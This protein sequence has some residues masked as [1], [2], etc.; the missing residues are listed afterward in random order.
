[1][2]IGRRTLTFGAVAAAAVTRA[3][4]AVAKERS[5]TM[6]GLITQLLTTSAGRD[7]LVRILV[8]ATKGMP[9]CL[10]YVVALDA[11]R[12]DAVWI[13]EVWTDKE[14]HAASLELPAVRAAMTKGRP[15]IS[16]IGSRTETRPVGAS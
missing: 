15:L 14:T 12:D 7:E 2:T 5:G 9:G 4:T 16:G 11:S 6:Y 8:G 13:T 1:M 3:E 10:S